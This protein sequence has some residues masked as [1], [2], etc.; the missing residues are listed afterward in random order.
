MKNWLSPLF[1][2][3]ERAIPTV[4]RTNG[5]LENSAGRLVPDPPRPVPVGSPVWAMN[6]SMTRWNTIPS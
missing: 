6:P 4:P 1:G 2:F 5:T 3:C